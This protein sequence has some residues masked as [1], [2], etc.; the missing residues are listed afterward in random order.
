MMVDQGLLKGAPLMGLDIEWPISRRFSV[1]GETSATVPIQNMPW[2]FSA[3]LLGRY[4][5]AGRGDGGVRAFGGLGYQR[6]SFQEQADVVSDFRSDSG[7]MLIIGIE[8][9]F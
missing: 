8:A 4:R 1:A 9:R 5:L 3:Q 2:I 6:I 7:A